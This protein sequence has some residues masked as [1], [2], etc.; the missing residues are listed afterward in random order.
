MSLPAPDALFEMCEYAFRAGKCELRCPYVGDDMAPCDKIWSMDEL[1]EKACLNPSEHGEFLLKITQTISNLQKVRDNISVDQE[2]AN[3]LNSCEWKK[4]GSNV[5]CPSTRAC[6]KCGAVIEHIMGCP[7][8][9]CTFPGCG[10]RFCFVCLQERCRGSCYIAPIQ[11]QVK[12]NSVTADGGTAATHFVRRLSKRL[13]KRMNLD[14][15]G[16]N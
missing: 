9:E 12:A 6:P 8:M 7:N 1:I 14:H 13:S 11:F 10:T 5:S 16:K 15:S 2:L 3:I 4:I